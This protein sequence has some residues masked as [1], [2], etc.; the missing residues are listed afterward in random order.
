M[1]ERAILWSPRM[2]LAIFNTLPGSD[3]AVAIDSGEP[4]KAETRR[5]VMVTIP[6]TRGKKQ[7]L[8]KVYRRAEWTGSVWTFH[9]PDLGLELSAPVDVGDHLWGRESWAVSKRWDK[10]RPRDLPTPKSDDDGA[11]LLVKTSHTWFRA[12]G[13]ADDEVDAYGAARGRWRPGRFMP[14]AY[15]RILHEVTAV[16]AEHLQDIRDEAFALEGFETPPGGDREG[17]AAG[18]D[19]IN[20]ER[21]RCAWDNNPWVRV[22]GLKRLDVHGYNQGE[23]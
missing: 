8:P 3:P 14:R 11:H 23:Q 17:F 18:W 5:I 12:D 16:R 13:E 15:S 20:G 21:P 6:G 9:G 7:P 19:A 22:I 4:L 2:V 1:K 10:D